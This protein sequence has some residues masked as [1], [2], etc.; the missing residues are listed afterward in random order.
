MQYILQIDHGGAR[1][2]LAL[3]VVIS[4]IP[5]QVSATGTPSKN[6]TY[7]S[8]RLDTSS[9]G[10]EDPGPLQ[11]LLQPANTAVAE[12]QLPANSLASLNENK[13]WPAKDANSG[14]INP[15]ALQAAGALALAGAYGGAQAASS[16]RLQPPSMIPEGS[17]PQPVGSSYT[18]GN[19]AA[20]PG[21]QAFERGPIDTKLLAP[22]VEKYPPAP[23]EE[24]ANH[25]HTHVIA[26][27]LE[28]TS[29]SLLPLNSSDSTPT[30]VSHTPNSSS[31]YT[32][33]C[34]FACLAVLGLAT[35]VI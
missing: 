19:K 16:S 34:S 18:A 4:I 23:E 9:T 21:V 12:Q 33:A 11:A 27:A 1:I 13:L 2:I 35:L 3:F 7:T 30:E 10:I 6:F 15:G 14:L 17:T 26:P 5:L 28:Q 22:I 29:T 32:H 25:D 8:I 31:T 20:T 24:S